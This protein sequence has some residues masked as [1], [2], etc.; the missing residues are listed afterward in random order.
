MAR[1]VKG[2]KKMDQIRF[3]LPVDEKQEFRAI[4]EAG[5]YNMSAVLRK[6]INEFIESKTVKQTTEKPK[7]ERTQT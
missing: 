2:E 6:A 5:G 4:C 7:K 3:L 1:Q